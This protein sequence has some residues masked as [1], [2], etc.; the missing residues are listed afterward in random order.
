[1]RVHRLVFKT[2]KPAEFAAE[3]AKMPSGTDESKVQIDHIDGDKLNNA[4]SNLRPMD[5]RAHNSKHAASIVWIDE[6]GGVLGTYASAAEAAR[7]VRGKDGRLLHNAAILAVCKKARTHTGG[8][9]FVYAEDERSNEL[10]A[11]RAGKKRKID[12]LYNVE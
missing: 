10:K 5:S 4:L 11:S 2:F 7:S 8:L 3:L 9:K 6:L 12:V 1:V